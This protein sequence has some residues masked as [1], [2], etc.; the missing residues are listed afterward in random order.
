MLK[1]EFNKLIASFRIKN[2]GVSIGEVEL[3]CLLQKAIEN[4]F[5]S[6]SSV[7][8]CHGSAGFVDYHPYGPKSFKRECE[9]SD[10]LLVFI[11]NNECRYTFMQNKYSKSS[12]VFVILKADII[13]YHLLSNRLRFAPISKSLALNGNELS[14]A[15]LD[16]AG[17]YGD[18]CYDTSTNTFDMRYFCASDLS[19]A[20]P[21]TIKPKIGKKR[22][23]IQRKL[24]LNKTLWSASKTRI[25]R[26]LQE[27]FYCSTLDD[28]EYEGR[29]MHIGTPICIRH[30]LS[31]RNKV[32][33]I[34]DMIVRNILFAAQDNPEVVPEYMR[35]LF[36]RFTENKESN[37]YQ[38][39]PT[40]VINVGDDDREYQ[41]YFFK[42]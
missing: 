42:Y 37:N 12:N 4:C 15:L 39:I 34:D 25:R 2:P 32:N 17:T 33:E 36:N 35:R 6:A 11:N 3:F 5:L 20:K 31:K 21:Y 38:Y 41:E 40:I 28:F 27:C 7:K 1:N 14:S 30:V 8:Q 23:V 19:T 9:I 16:T 29:A 10:L 13:Q 22:N 18:F 26:H 24:T